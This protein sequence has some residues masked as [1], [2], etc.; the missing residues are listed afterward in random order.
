MQIV[1]EKISKYTNYEIVK[2]AS[3]TAGI[4]SSIKKDRNMVI[5]CDPNNSSFV[6]LSALSGWGVQTA[7]A[8]SEITSYLAT[9]KNIPSQIID[10][11][12]NIDNLLIS[13]LNRTDDDKKYN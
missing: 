13:R 8:Y 3:K 11:G 6:W 5:G 12:I 1:L 2:I 9:N 4:K 7:A 10:Y